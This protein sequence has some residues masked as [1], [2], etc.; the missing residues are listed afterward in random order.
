M[1]LL[2]LLRRDLGTCLDTLLPAACPWC[3]RL[4][5]PGTDQTSICEACRRGIIDCGPACCPRCSQPHATL[6]VSPH[7]CEVCLRM[8]P[9]FEKV[10]TVGRYQNSLKKAIHTFKYR[11]D[12]ALAASLSH[13]LMDSLKKVSEDF[14]P[15]R[16]I[17]V[18]LHPRRLRQRG[19]NQALELA[20]P[21]AR[22]LEV[23]LDNRLLE[24]IRPTL[25]QQDLD[26]RAR[27]SNLR[28]AFALTGGLHGEDLLLIDDVM[29]TGTTARECGLALKRGGAGRIRIAVLG[30]A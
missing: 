12:P 20:K 11:D 21:V 27:R 24:R 7:Y 1:A 30:R 26:A 25:P 19:Y 17:P 5:K 10:H 28:N 16:V 3:G 2:Q 6:A 29:T 23:L 15:K 14:Q 9:P 13:L 22:Q 8:P 4:L 18:P